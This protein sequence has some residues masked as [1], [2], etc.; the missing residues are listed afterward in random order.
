MPRRKSSASDGDDHKAK[1]TRKQFH[2]GGGG[3]KLHLHH[4][5]PSHGKKLNQLTK[6]T[7]MHSADNAKESGLGLDGSPRRAS[8]QRSASQRSLAELRQTKRS[9]SSQD[10]KKLRRPSA[11]HNTSATRLQQLRVAAGSRV[12]LGHDTVGE[13]QDEGPS[14]GASGA[15]DQPEERDLTASQPTKPKTKPTFV[16]DEEERSDDE[17][18]AIAQGV[19]SREQSQSVQTPDPDSTSTPLEAPKCDAVGSR[20]APSRSSSMH[21]VA[22]PAF[23]RSPSMG[24][25]ARPK[26][27]A[28]VVRPQYVSRAPSRAGT[29][30]GSRTPVQ[31]LPSQSQPLTSRFLDSPRKVPLRTE[32]QNMV[33]SGDDADRAVDVSSQTVLRVDAGAASGIFYQSPHA[34]ATNLGGGSSRTQQKLLLQRA[35]SIYDVDT[36]AEATDETSKASLQSRLRRES[37][38]IAR[39]YRNVRRYRDPVRES[40][41]R[42]I[43]RRLLEASVPSSGSGSALRRSMTQTGLVDQRQGPR[44]SQSY[45]E[46]ARGSMRRSQTSSGEHGLSASAID[47]VLRSLWEDEAAASST[48]TPARA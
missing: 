10:V 5:V 8:M 47:L 33:G 25:P 40:G 38:R 20:R 11:N 12:A 21:D 36:V 13:W 14:A 45:G 3:S 26:V 27:T 43:A 48:S 42:L 37:D 9:A 22:A 6:L 24:Q 18:T 34:S 19:T 35:S 46:L 4:R 41:A 28:E 1:T 7:T 44:S 31:S 32:S 30:D 15:E 39:E 2:V 17:V 16:I 29:L 23:L